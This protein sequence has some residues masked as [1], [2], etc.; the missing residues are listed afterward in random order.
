MTAPAVYDYSAEKTARVHAWVNGDTYG[1]TIWVNGHAADL[2]PKYVR[3]RQ[4]TI[5][6]CDI[7]GR[8]PGTSMEAYLVPSKGNARNDAGYKRVAKALEV[9]RAHGYDIQANMWALNSVPVEDV[10]AKY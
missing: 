6:G 7:V 10:L 8:L 5:S 3:A 1:V 9:L 4:T 2:F